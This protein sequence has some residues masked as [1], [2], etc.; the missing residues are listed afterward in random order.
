M[1]WPWE[2]IEKGQGFFV[3]ALDVAKVREQ[4]LLAAV[5]LKITDARAKLCIKQGRLGVLFYRVPPAQR[6][7]P[8]S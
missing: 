2:K 8:E 6:S 3:P 7:Q 1:K 5:P 4:G